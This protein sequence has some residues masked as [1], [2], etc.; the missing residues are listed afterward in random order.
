MCVNVERLCL[1]KLLLAGF[2]QALGNIQKGEQQHPQFN[3]PK[4]IRNLT[5]RG[6]KV[7]GMPL[8]EACLL[9]T[10]KLDPKHGE[11]RPKAR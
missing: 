5:F 3:N 4:I 9:G 1:P 7:Y 2:R 6:W 10:V 8:E 11:S